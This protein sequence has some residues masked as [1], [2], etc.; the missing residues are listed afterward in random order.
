[1]WQRF[2]AIILMFTGTFTAP[3]CLF[4]G[5]EDDAQQ[6]LRRGMLAEQNGQTNAAERAYRQGIDLYPRIPQLHQNLALLLIKAGKP[7]EGAQYIA[8]ALYLRP[9]SAELR[10][11][12]ARS[13][14]RLG[15]TGDAEHLAREA[16]KV[17]NTYI[18]AYQTLAGVLI[19]SGR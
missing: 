19:A 13:L 18:P 3:V 6:L 16:I 9:N 11:D 14:A 4:A 17:Q 2:L 12:L 15:F 8:N 7:Q 1:M 10:N 5:P